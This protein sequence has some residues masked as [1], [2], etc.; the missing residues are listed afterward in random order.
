MMKNNDKII[1][2]LYK[3]YHLGNNSFFVL[4]IKNYYYFYLRLWLKY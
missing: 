2:L 4:V 1:K 3:I